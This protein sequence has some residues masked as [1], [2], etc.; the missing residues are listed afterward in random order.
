MTTRKAQQGMTLMGMIMALAVAGIFVYCG[1]KIIPMY[2]EY[3]S[4]KEAMD[5]VAKEPGIANANKGKLLQLIYPR[6][7]VS[8]VESVQ[9]DHFTLV[10]KPRPALQVKY[11]VR[12][13]LAYNLD[14][15]G[16]FEYSVD[17]SN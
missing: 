17:L 12:T 7:N 16:R 8:Y 1:M 4:V 11:E 3:M 15:V 10:T 13:P 9:P 5:E 2:T 14:V 6:L